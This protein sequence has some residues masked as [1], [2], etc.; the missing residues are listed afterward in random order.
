ML[1]LEWRSCRRYENEAELRS[2]L[3]GLIMFSV[4]SSIRK[5][6]RT[7]RPNSLLVRDLFVCARPVLTPILGMRAAVAFQLLD[8]SG[9]E[10]LTQA[11]VY[12]LLK[13]IVR[14]RPEFGAAAR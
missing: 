9:E 2:V 12:A 11:Q 4:I 8:P 10:K 1:S 5:F 14:V 7:S 13:A 6:E 3:I